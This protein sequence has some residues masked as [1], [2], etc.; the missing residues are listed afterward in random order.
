MNSALMTDGQPLLQV[1]G[2]SVVFDDAAAPAV[3]GVSW[4]LRPGRVTALVGESGSGKTVSAMAVLGLLPEAAVVAGS[5]RLGAGLSG[6]GSGA[7]LVGA[8]V[9]TFREV[10]GAVLSLVS[11]E[12]MSAWNP[13]LT[14]GD[15]IAEALRAHRRGPDRPN[16]RAAHERVLELLLEAGLRDP[17]RVAA[18]YPHQLSGGQLQ[19]AL[20]AMG[21]SQEPVAIIADEPTTA[22]DVT[23]QAGILDLLRGLRDERGTA[24]LLI[25]HDMGVVADLA[26]D[27]VVMRDGRVVEAAPVRELFAAPREEYT[28]TLLAAVPRLGERTPPV[29]LVEAFSSGNRVPTGSTGGV[30]SSG[31]VGSTGGAGAGSTS[32]SG[33]AV[34]LDDVTVTYGGRHPVLAADGVTLEIGSGEVLGLVGESGSGKSTL[35]QVVAGLLRPTSGRAVVDGVDLARASRRQ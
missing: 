2:L 9:E 10:R 1:E 30:G 19:R 29:E 6:A 33:A 16:R 32:G 18:S 14:V 4:A 25:T 13:V 12:P 24:V 8:S 5:I 20:V 35:G 34:L 15:Q 21:L 28:R 22:L 23:V 3:D 11:Q 7:E 31:G 27:V 17:E 26:D